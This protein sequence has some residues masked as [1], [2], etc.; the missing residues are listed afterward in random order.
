[1]IQAVLLFLV[2]IAVVGIL[3]GRRKRRGPPRIDRDRQPRVGRTRLC[4]HCSR[5]IVGTNRCDCGQ[6]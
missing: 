1:M 3:S 6:G 4:P 5:L 2:L